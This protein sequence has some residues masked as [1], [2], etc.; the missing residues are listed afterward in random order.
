METT[1]IL[2]AVQVDPSHY[3]NTEAHQLFIT[4]T[5]EYLTQFEVDGSFFLGKRVESP[6]DHDAMLSAGAHIISLLA[7]A[8]PQQK[9][10]LEDLQI[11]PDTH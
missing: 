1:S 5:P 2:I 4:G 7:K 3:K 9:Y 10:T 11:F 6:I 8:C